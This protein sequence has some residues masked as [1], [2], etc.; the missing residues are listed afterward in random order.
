MELSLLFGV[1]F[2]AYAAIVG[3]NDACKLWDVDRKSS[4]LTGV[5]AFGMELMSAY[6]I[7][8]LVS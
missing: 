8:K 7:M 3:F 2:G 1:I 5:A 4:V 6:A